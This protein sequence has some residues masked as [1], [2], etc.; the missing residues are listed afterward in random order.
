[1]SGGGESERPHLMPEVFAGRGG[2]GEYFAHQARAHS[3]V[4]S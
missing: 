4:A 3:G 1:M 2:H